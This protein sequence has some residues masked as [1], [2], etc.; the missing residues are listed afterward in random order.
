M[1]CM[2]RKEKICY[3]KILW[4]KYINT[5]S[6]YIRIYNL[7]KWLQ[8]S[9]TPHFNLLLA[10]D[11]HSTMLFPSYFVR[12]FLST[13]LAFMC[14][15]P[16]TVRVYVY[17]LCCELSV[18]YHR[19]GLANSHTL[20]CKQQYTAFICHILITTFAHRV[21]C[22]FN[23]KQPTGLYLHRQFSLRLSEFLVVAECTGRGQNQEQKH[24]AIH[25]NMLKT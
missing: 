2:Q 3:H 19:F 23:C 25:Y 11:F 24:S 22:V 6:Q 5:F 18:V 13:W 20:F 15:V 17:A 21:V 4:H 7:Q 10:H 12:V 8:Q 1:L 16:A 14:H 9:T